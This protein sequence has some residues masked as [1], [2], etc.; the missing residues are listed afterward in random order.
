MAPDGQRPLPQKRYYDIFSYLATQ[1]GFCF[2][3]APFV[4]LSFPESILVWS[5]VYFYA[6]TG[7]AASIAFFASPAKPWLNQ[8]LKQRNRPTFQR[9]RTDS[10]E[11]MANHPVLG[12]P[13]DPAKEFDEAFQE[14]KAE[15][16]ARSRRGSTAATVDGNEVQKVFEDKLGKQLS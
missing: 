16:E 15:V 14:A 5:R 13:V 4:I 11:A 10:Q 6:I 2:V 1:L 12:L 7:V 3:T 9:S 8:Q